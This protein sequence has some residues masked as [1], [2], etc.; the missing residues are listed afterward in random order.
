[1]HTMQDAHWLWALGSI[2]ALNRLPF[3]PEL[4]ARD[5]PPP[6]DGDSLTRAASA[7]G[8]RLQALRLS[9]RRLGK[10]R[11]P[12]IVGLKPA[13]A[14]SDSAESPA[15]I[16]LGIVTAA[17]TEEVLLFRAGETTPQTLDLAEFKNRTTGDAWLATLADESPRDPDAAALMKPRFGFGWF[18]PELLK[19]KRV[20]RDVLIASASLQ[21]IA[22]TTPLFTQAIVDKVVVH[23]TQST[24]IAIGMAMAIFLLF[25]SLLTW[26][27]QYLV[28]HTGNRIDAVLG[29]A[30]WGHLLRLPLRYFEHRPT[31]VI[32]ARLQGVET[33]REFISSAAV[34]LLLDL[35]FLVVCLGVMF[36]YSVL[37]T[38]VALGVVAVIGLGSVVV[39]PMFQ[40]RLNEQFLLGARSQAFVTEHIAGFETVKSL[41]M[42]PQLRQ[43]YSAYLTQ[44]LR[45]A[46][47]TK[48][49]GNSYNVFATTLEQA[50]TMAI[51]MLG[52]WTVMTEPAFT[53]GMLVAFQMLT[54]RLSQPVLRIVGLWSQF[55][56]AKL[57]VDRLGDLMN[58]PRGTLQPATPARRWRARSTRA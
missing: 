55:Q 28:L 13:E 1:M 6:H 22:L 42:E 21:V 30:V 11:P 14:E 36:W 7:L 43:R 33:I 44:Y 16:E 15:R 29:T 52:A 10:L 53:I 9:P 47:A 18:M 35:P 27:R 37:L 58:A 39:A 49:L 56:Q 34:T 46:F 12:L 32:A 45:A 23:R 3:S 26:L 50:L 5:H 51:L 20:W 57:S 25:T 38:A 4:V 2:C 8:V 19:Y 48:Q 41:Q 54:G 24:L 31:G 17:S 40:R